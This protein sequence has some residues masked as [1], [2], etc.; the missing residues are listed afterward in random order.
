MFYDVALVV[1]SATDLGV[2]SLYDKL[3]TKLRECSY[4]M[5][6]TWAQ[7]TTGCVIVE[8]KHITCKKG[9]ISL[10]TN[11]CVKEGEVGYFEVVFQKCGY[12][13]SCFIAVV[14]GESRNYSEKAYF[15][16][17]GDGKSVYLGG[18]SRYYSENNTFYH[19]RYEFKG[20]TLSDTPT[21]GVFMDMRRNKNGKVY[22]VV[23]GDIK[24]LMY[25]G[26]KAPV[27][28][29]VSLDREQATATIIDYETIPADWLYLNLT[30]IGHDDSICASKIA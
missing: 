25:D 24:G 19:D 30:T 23:D 18:M 17:L 4:S 12:N 5:N 8:N 27:Y 1:S 29:G 22:L 7:C 21:V 10:I 14:Q 13:H 16:N 26:L 2:P 3:K 9:W 20:V 28:P 6:F 15:G 11:E